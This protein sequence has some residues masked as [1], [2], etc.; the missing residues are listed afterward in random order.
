MESMKDLA[1][2]GRLV[3][4]VIH[5]PR[6]SIFNMFDRLLL[7]SEGRTMYSGVARDAVDY[8]ATGG[9]NCQ[10]FYNPSDFFLDILSPD[11]RSPELEKA[12][13]ERILMLGDA[14]AERVSRDL[15][16]G[17]SLDDLS[18]LAAAG[19]VKS[20]GTSGDVRKAYMNFRVLCWRAWSEQ[21]RD[22][23]TL[24][25]KNF[26][27]LFFALI[28]GG[29]YSNIG[30]NQ[31]SIQNRNGFLFFITINIAFSGLIGV[32]NT[33]PKEKNIVNRERSSRAYDTVSYFI[34]KFMVEIPLNTIPAVL[35]S[36]V[37][38]W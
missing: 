30:Y 33:F 6:S 10:Q 5:Q 31:L 18:K 29:I 3:I 15:N 21:S 17:I 11:N 38:Y 13:S 14:W 9:F 25:F 19:E 16:R 32:L 2:N 28:I 24:V 7:L 20:I 8:F 36:C 4:S 37:V 23:L 22:W 34:A 1:K 27:L 26:F 12:S 35:Y